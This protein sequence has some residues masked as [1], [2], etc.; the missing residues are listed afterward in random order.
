MIT[1]HVM[2]ISDEMVM[3]LRNIAMD[4]H[5]T[6]LGN[7]YDADYIIMGEDS[8]WHKEVEGYTN[9]YSEEQFRTFIKDTKPEYFL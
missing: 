5:L 1:V 6:A 9:I 2:G 3:F 4:G 8:S 7:H